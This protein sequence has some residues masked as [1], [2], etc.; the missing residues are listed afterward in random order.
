MIDLSKFRWPL[1]KSP[2]G[3]SAP[4]AT[5]ALD[6]VHDEDLA[7]PPQR[8]APL[9]A[10][11]GRRLGEPTKLFPNQ[12][13]RR[14]GKNTGAGWNNFL[15][16]FRAFGL[17]GQIAGINTFLNGSSTGSDDARAL[18]DWGKAL[19]WAAPLRHF[20]NAG[21]E[22][23]A[24]AKYLSL[25]KL[26][27]HAARLRFVWIED[28]IEKTNRVVLA[29]CVGGRNLILD[30]RRADIALDCELPHYRPYCS[31][32]ETDFALHWDASETAGWEESLKQL[33]SH[34]I[35]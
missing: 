15:E 14:R 22:N 26:G 24:L 12:A 5:P 11:R 35:H 27:V 9:F 6:A 4:P 10:A 19:P 2:G 7:M 23:V 8:P 13:R 25:R 32:G 28:T 33:G 31:L 34:A 30:S 18:A 1:A 17:R 16:G 21:S 20:R 3:A 29:L